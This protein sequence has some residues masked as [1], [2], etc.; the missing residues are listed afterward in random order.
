MFDIEV[1]RKSELNEDITRTYCIYRYINMNVQIIIS[2]APCIEV[3]IAI[4]FYIFNAFGNNQFLIV[5]KNPF[6]LISY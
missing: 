5:I 4:Y 6:P 2:L 3:N 1:H